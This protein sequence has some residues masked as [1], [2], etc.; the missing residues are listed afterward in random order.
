MSWPNFH[1]PRAG[2][3]GSGEPGVCADRP[4]HREAFRP[5]CFPPLSLQ[6]FSGDQ[7]YSKQKS[8]L[9]FFFPK[10][11]K[12]QESKLS[13]QTS[14]RAAEEEPPPWKMTEPVSLLIEDGGG[15]HGAGPPDKAPGWPQAVSTG[16]LPPTGSPGFQPLGFL[17]ILRTSLKPINKTDFKPNE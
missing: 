9:L 8:E 4:H 6:V 3:A 1:G 17:P 16:P 11:R 12:Q 10:M 13:R 14:Q 5:S 7:F 15:L 2:G